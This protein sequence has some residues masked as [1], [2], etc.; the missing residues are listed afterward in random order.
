MDIINAG[1]IEFSVYGPM[2]SAQGDAEGR[3]YRLLTGKGGR[4][5]VVADQEA[6]AENIYA[7]GGKGSQGMGGRTMTFPLVEGGEV[8]FIG[9]WKASASGLFEE[10]GFD[11][12]DTYFCRG[13]IALEREAGKW[14]GPD[15]YRDIL[16]F[17]EA[18]VL[19]A[20]GWLEGRAKEIAN[21][22][23]RPVYVGEITKGGGHAGQVTP[24]AQAALATGATQ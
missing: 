2:I 13:V 10:T 17:D 6:A 12:R 5:W 24:D 4:R 3:K 19:R 15:A 9:P 21:E 16:H 20:F 1:P 7:D 8:E 22:L 23:G 14:P 11:V 18:P